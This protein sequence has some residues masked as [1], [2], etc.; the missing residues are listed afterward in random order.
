MPGV[1][2]TISRGRAIRLR[3]CMLRLSP[4]QSRCVPLF[5]PMVSFCAS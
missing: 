2:T 3:S 1:A 4:P 5:V